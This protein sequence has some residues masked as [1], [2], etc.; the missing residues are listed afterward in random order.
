MN[1]SCLTGYNS[2]NIRITRVELLTKYKLRNEVYESKFRM[3][4]DNVYIDINHLELN[5]VLLIESK[6]S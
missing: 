2:I 1:V 4:L 5:K 3:E 6:F